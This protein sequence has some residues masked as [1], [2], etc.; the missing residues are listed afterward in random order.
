MILGGIKVVLK[1]FYDN[2]IYVYKDIDRTFFRTKSYGGMM[3]LQFDISPNHGL[4]KYL[5]PETELEYDGQ[6]YLV[7]GINERSTANPITTINAE[8]DLTGLKKKAYP[9]YN[10]ETESFYNVCRE[11]MSG[12]G[13]DVVNAEMVSKRTTLELKDVTPLEILEHCT[14]QTAYNT[15]YEFDTID[16]T[17]TCIKPENN[18]EPTGTYFTDELN[19][20]ELTYKGSSQ[21]LVTKLYVYGKDGLTIKSVNPTGREYITNNTYS[22][23]EIA[24]VWR[25]ERYTAAKSLYDDAVAKLEILSKPEQSYTVKVIDLAKLLPDKY[26]TA[27]KYKLYDVVTLIDRKRKTRTN[28]RI[29]EIKEYPADHT[30]DTVTLS[31]ITAKVTGKITT[32]DNKISQLDAQQLYDRTKVNEIKQDLDTTVLHISESWADSVN[33][34]LFTQTAEGLYLQADKIVGDDRIGTLIQQS[35]ADIKIA[36]NKINQYIQ[37]SDAEFK[38]RNNAGNTLM[39]LNQYGQTINDDNGIKLMEL[40]STGQRFYYKGNSVGEIGT[41]SYTGDESARGLS[42]DLENGASYMCWAWRESIDANIYSIKLAYMAK[43]IGSFDADR[44]HVMCPFDLNNNYIY[45]PILKNWSFDGGSISGTFSGCYVT[46]FN[47]DGTVKTWKN[48]KLVFKS[49]ILQSAEW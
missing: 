33:E 12:T 2:N 13:W 25:D 37:F 6:K 10:R 30:L 40:S 36:W 28:H 26:G 34:S 21:S 15:C 48:F 47:A 1:I 16:Q 35:P 32:L 7:K 14:N 27:L 22:D 5:L 49:G 31:T 9:K 46:A 39:T 17:I 3:Y 41:N 45:D 29:V 43:K 20:S 4:Y 19:I 44:L 23:K 24:A 11:I 38:I 8:L 18:T 42:F